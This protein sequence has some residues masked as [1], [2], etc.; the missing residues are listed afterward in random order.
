MACSLGEGSVKLHQDLKS[1]PVHMDR[2]G[3]KRAAAGIE[4]RIVT[5][6]F[7]GKHPRASKDTADWYMQIQEIGSQALRE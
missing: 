5:V 4:D 2:E 6:V 1:N 3:V 7:P